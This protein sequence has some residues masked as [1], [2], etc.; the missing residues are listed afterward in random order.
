MSKIYIASIVVILATILPALG[1]KISTE[2]LTELI[3]AFVV[4]AGGVFIMYKRYK[5]GGVTIAGTRL[6]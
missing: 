6:N 4:V 3:Q 2:E 1:I 5:M